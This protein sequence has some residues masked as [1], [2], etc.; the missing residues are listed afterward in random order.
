MGASSSYR[1]L[2]YIWIALLCVGVL[3]QAGLAAFLIREIN[4]RQEDDA[5]QL[6]QIQQAVT[7]LCDRGYLLADLIL[8]AE[9]LVR[10]TPPLTAQERTFLRSYE[11]HYNEL[12]DEVSS[13]DSPCVS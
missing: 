4:L 3:L 11:L 8:E 10:S 6:A 2:L 5:A 12:L 13:T 1:R 7:L 9:D